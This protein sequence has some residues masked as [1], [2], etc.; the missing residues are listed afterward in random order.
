MRRLALVALFG[1]TSWAAQAAD[2]VLYQPVPAWVKPV[3]PP[4]PSKT[5]SAGSDDV[6]VRVLLADQ[7]VALEPGTVTIYSDMVMQIGTPQGLAAGNIS[8]PWQPDTSSLIVHRLVIRRGDTVIDVL[9]AGQ[10]FTVVRRETN[11]DSAMLDGM[12]TANIQP[13]G[14]QV[15]DV[16]EL[17]ASV[18]WRD[19]VMQR[20]AEFVGGAWNDVPIGRAHLRAQWPSA[21]SVRFK[22]IG[23]G[24]AEVKP[25]R[26]GDTTAVE[27][28]L[29]GV[30]PPLL[31]KG[32]PPRFQIGR[33][34]EASTFATWGDVAA[35]MAPLYAKAATLP[36]DGPL[37]AEVA[38]IRAASTDPLVRTQ[39]ALVLVQDRIR[40]VALAM[41]TGGL[42]P[43]DAATTWSRRF[44]DCKGKTVLLIAM[45]RALGVTADAVAV[46]TALGDGLDARLPRA[47]AFDHVVVRAVIAGKTYW[48][49]GTRSGDTSLERLAVPDFRWGLPLVAGDATL[50]RILPKPF[51]RPQ[52][53]VT[54]RIDARGGLMT[55]APVTV[56][57]VVRGDEAIGLGAALASLSGEARDRALRDYWKRE[58]DFIDIAS[59][60]TSADAATGERRLTMT[61]K[62]RMDWTS[63][64]Y[65]TDGMGIGYRADFARDAGPDRDAPFAVPYPYYTRTVETILLP[66][67]FPDLKTEGKNDI[68]AT[69]AGIEY[70]RRVSLTNG[71]FTAE[72]TERSLVPEFPAKDAPAAQA[73]LRDLADQSLYI[74]RPATY[75]VTD[76]DLAVWQAKTLTSDD[77]FVDR[78]NVLLDRGRLDE[79]LKDFEAA[80][81][82][83]P[84][85]VTARADRGVTRAWQGDFA[86]AEADFAAVDKVAPNNAIVWRGRGLAAEKQATFKPAA[87]AYTRALTIEPGNVFSLVGR[88]RAKR[89]LGDNDGALADLAA[90]L[91]TAPKNPDAYLLRANILRSMNKPDAVIAEADALL[92][93]MP[94]SDYAQVSAAKLYAASG[95]KTAALA[96]FDRALAIKPAAYI[97]FN[98][99][100]I[101]DRSDHAGRAADIAAAAKLEP[102]S[103][104]VLAYRAT[105]LM[106]DGKFA[107]AVSAYD[108]QL[109]AL[110]GNTFALNARGVAKVR[111]GDVKGGEADLAAAAAKASEPVDFNNLCWAKATAGIALSSALAD[112]DKA[113]ARSPKVAGFLDSKG[114]VLLRLN[115]NDEAIATYDAAVAI[116]PDLAGSLYGRS[117]A[118]QRKGDAA[119]AAAD[120]TAALKSDAQIVAEFADFGVTG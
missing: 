64:W 49:D 60:T 37:A 53:E 76:A 116:A 113:L 44:G 73:K 65:E 22:G 12:L 95:R 91:V 107:D 72:R 5:P 19:P 117:I 89:A 34:F 10:T 66:P 33:L 70:R 24:L 46:S 59:A 92:R 62:A 96:A 58:Y 57:R 61:G 55:P 87:D 20:N 23:A 45:L 54:I 16:V 109:A 26:T 90:A 74:R 51:E 56:E 43:A 86:A 31:P 99:F 11:L 112:C 6:P 114:L 41:G 3:A 17:A 78:G 15:G 8:L 120:R 82:I 68:A 52:S 115:R 97:Y 63:G 77:A 84:G 38:R 9:G 47:S 101:R 39:A 13:E 25:I 93:A 1:S 48:L 83:A 32:A 105:M 118:W 50:V 2:K 71:T 98:R 94:D 106:Q 100:D 29:D 7:Q 18:V 88:A 42:V 80:L 104:S 75:A 14:L 103:P 69:V 4:A 79:A 81:S 36:A 28:A 111:A 102:D 35:M 67:G 110:P 108:A 21:M 85:N 27:I 40:Y 119:R 30:V